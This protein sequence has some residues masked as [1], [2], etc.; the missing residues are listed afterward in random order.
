MQNA[1]RRMHTLIHDLL[2]YS[3]VSTTKKLFTEVDLTRS[4]KYTLSD[5]ETQIVKT[6]GKINLDKLP[7]I[8]ANPTQMRQLFQ[9]LISNALK[10]HKKNTAPQVKIY[11]KTKAPENHCIIVVEDNGIGI[12]KENFDKI[13]GVFQ[14]VY[15]SD[16][17]E[18]SGIGLAICKNIIENHNGTIQI[19]SKVNQGT[20]FIICLPVK[21][22]TKS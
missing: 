7:T 18:G 20:K 11:S 12:K 9:N 4:V 19:K 22:I 6:L 21:Q 15:T 14:R 16:K 1:A 10:F 3:R 17:Y 2:T 13:F 5:L 8:E